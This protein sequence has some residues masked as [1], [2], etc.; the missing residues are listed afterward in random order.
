MAMS[1][2]YIHGIEQVKI[3][4]DKIRENNEWRHARDHAGG[5]AQGLAEWMTA[6]M[7]PMEAY[8]V[9]QQV[10]DG[11]VQSQLPKG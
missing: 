4:L 11:I 1:P 5:M 10:A 7:G 2:A 6:H 8:K 9:M 3:Y